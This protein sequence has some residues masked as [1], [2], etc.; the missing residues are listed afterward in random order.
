[1]IKISLFTQ[2][3]SLNRYGFEKPFL[4]RSYPRSF[5]INCGVRYFAFV[6]QRS[7]NRLRVH[8]R[9]AIKGPK[10]YQPVENLVPHK[11]VKVKNY[12]C[13]NCYDGRKV[14]GKGGDA[15]LRIPSRR[16]GI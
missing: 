13:A 7:N 1:M 5:T 6:C 9:L 10:V 14:E 12:C 15:G 2:P 11:V 4:V 3:F 16:F 8:G